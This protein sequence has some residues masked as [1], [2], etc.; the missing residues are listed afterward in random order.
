VGALA[1]GGAGFADGPLSQALFN[2]PHGL[3][4]AGDDL[5][6]VADSLNHRVRAI[7]GATVSTL[8]GDGTI[9]SVNGPAAS[10]RFN[11][12]SGLAV[13]SR[14]EIY[15]ADHYNNQVRIIEGG[16]VT[17][18]SGNPSA[19]YQDGPAAIAQFFWPPS[20]AFVAPDTVYVSDGYNH[21]MRRI[22]LAQ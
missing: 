7:S 20:V 14:G 21:R 17:T 18:L 11:F 13:G 3:V 22:T 1:G 8:A 4:L 5:L 9:G 2:K 12:P 10:A 6:Y 16:V 15:V 19:G